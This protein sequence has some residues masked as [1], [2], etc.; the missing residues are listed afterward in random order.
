MSG[1]EV[2]GVV[3]ALL[4]LAIKAARAYAVILS[5]NRT[6]KYEL[7]KLIQDLETEEACLRNTCELLLMGIV[8]HN[9]V[10]KLVKTP[11]GPEWEPFNEKMRLRLWHTHASF[12]KHIDEMLAATKE[13]HEKLCVTADGEVKHLTLDLR[14]LT[15]SPCVQSPAM[16]SICTR[17]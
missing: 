3:L 5:S 15:I 13:L 10:D 16:V 11:F 12:V 14:T 8:P 1:F 17:L 4:P 7:T 2:A 9:A 6:A